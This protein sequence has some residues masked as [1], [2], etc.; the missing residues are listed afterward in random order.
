MV[1][2]SCNSVELKLDFLLLIF[3]H[4]GEVLEINYIWWANFK[5]YFCFHHLIFYMPYFDNYKKFIAQIINY[6][7]VLHGFLIF[8]YARLDINQFWKIMY[9]KIIVPHFN[10]HSLL[11]YLL[12]FFHMNS[13][14]DGVLSI[15]A[16][17]YYPLSYYARVTG[18]KLNFYFWEINYHFFLEYLKNWDIFPVK[19]Y[20]N[21]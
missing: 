4:H 15:Y 9:V 21:Y 6:R 11:W 14:Y 2:L 1:Y 16:F 3:W 7:D 5:N 18:T 13:F 19:L 12:F 17:L 20:Q 10:F 8:K